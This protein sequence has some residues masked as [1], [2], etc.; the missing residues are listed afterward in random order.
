M[1]WTTSSEATGR[2]VLRNQTGL[3]VSHLLCCFHII[4]LEY[5]P[6]VVSHHAARVSAQC[7][8]RLQKLIFSLNK[9]QGQRRI[10]PS[11]KF[12]ES[13]LALQGFVPILY[14]YKKRRRSLHLPKRGSR[15]P[16]SD[17]HKRPTPQKGCCPW[18]YDQ[19]P[20]VKSVQQTEVRQK[21]HTCVSVRLVLA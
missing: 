18:P 7:V 15:L 12:P 1:R 3:L 13:F 4:P 5:I 8:L 2:V 9:S 14:R 17:K 19:R 6:Q 20:T 10:S 11:M 16:L 21:R